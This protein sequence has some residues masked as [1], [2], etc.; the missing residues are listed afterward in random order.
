M[1]KIISG[2]IILGIV[3]VGL[4]ANA[5][6]TIEKQNKL[7]IPYDLISE[8]HKSTIT[9]SED[10]VTILASKGTDLYT[11]SDGSKSADNAPRI[12]F[13]PKSDFI[14]SAKV[15]ADFTS[16]YDGGALFIY[17]DTENWT[18]FLFERFKS[19]DNG[20]SS[21][22]TKTTGDDAYHN[23][24]T[25]NEV[26]LKIAREKD[27]FTLFYSTDGEHWL[28]RRSFSLISKTPIKVGFIAQSPISENHK[29]VY[30]NIQFK[31]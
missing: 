25:S 9:V 21:T 12:F 11:N 10:T 24:I 19:G 1:A 4:I 5:E 6:E 13:T 15:T 2:L 14:F 31:E 22:V 28:Y 8:P 20:I 3:F 16:A 18:K 30:S 26:Y 23:F 7:G 27:T 17:G 29:V